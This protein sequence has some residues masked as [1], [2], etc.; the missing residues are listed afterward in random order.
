MRFSLKIALVVMVA[1]FTAGCSLPVTKIDVQSYEINKPGVS[2]GKAM[3]KLTTVFVNRNFDIKLANKEAGIITTEYKLFTSLGGNPPFDYYMQIKGRISNVKGKTRISLLPLVKE[4]NRSN[5]A[6]YTEHELSYYVGDPANV[7]LI[8]SMREG[9]GWRNIGQTVFM[10]VVHDAA[11]VFGVS[12]DDI[13]Q[14]VTKTPANAFLLE[15]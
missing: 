2:T 9:T 4:Q 14:N 15:K 7:R 13:V 12:M 3:A 6:A 1:Y 11:E 5:A 10:N 8:R